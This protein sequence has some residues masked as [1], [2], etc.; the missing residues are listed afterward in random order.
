MNTDP[1]PQ[2]RRGRVCVPFVSLE[3][4]NYFFF[5]PPFFFAFL[6]AMVLF[7]LSVVHGTCNDQLLQLMN[8]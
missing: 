2:K 3:G 6:V 7:S 1:W 8:V 4:R 5:L